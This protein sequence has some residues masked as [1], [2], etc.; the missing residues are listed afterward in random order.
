MVNVAYLQDWA[1]RSRLFRLAGVE[2]ASVD[3][4]TT[5]W[6]GRLSGY[7]FKYNQDSYGLYVADSTLFFFASGN[8]WR[9]DESLVASYGRILMV[10]RFSLRLDNKAV[11]SRTYW[12]PEGLRELAADPSF[13]EFDENR[14]FFLRWCT[15][16]LNS[17]MRQRALIERWGHWRW[18]A[19][20]RGTG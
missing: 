17:P 1:N 13:D 15:G 4:E 20:P 2:I 8:V 7:G 19:I 14:V 9:V 11:F 12:R 3:P 5:Q 10:E 6:P 16:V 18:K